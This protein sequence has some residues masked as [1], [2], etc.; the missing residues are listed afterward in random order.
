MLT[1]DNISLI[2]VPKNSN[3]VCTIVL[4]QYAVNLGPSPTHLVWNTSIV[5]AKILNWSSYAKPA[6][7]PLSFP[8]PLLLMGIWSTFEPQTSQW[9][10]KN[11]SRTFAFL[12]KELQDTQSHQHL[13]SLLWICSLETWNICRPTSVSAHLLWYAECVPGGREASVQVCG[14]VIHPIPGSDRRM[15]GERLETPLPGGAG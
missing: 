2:S 7:L 14:R 6:K 12:E 4:H 10:T 3:G 8:I 15:S 13:A 1:L 5:M 9:S 11:M